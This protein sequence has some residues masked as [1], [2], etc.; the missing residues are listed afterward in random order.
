M[1][2]DT[3]TSLQM[4]APSHTPAPSLDGAALGGS[5]CSP[6][7]YLRNADRISQ[8]EDALRWALDHCQPSSISE[9]EMTDYPE[10]FRKAL[11]LLKP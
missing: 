7:S 5:P 10:K 2:P 1:T 4:Q 8:L 9:K 11:S 6:F 3:A